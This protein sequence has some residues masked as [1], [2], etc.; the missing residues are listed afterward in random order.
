M[1]T[2]F[3]REESAHSEASPRG[4]L[5]GLRGTARNRFSSIAQEHKQNRRAQLED[6]KVDIFIDPWEVYSIL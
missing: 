1:D 2:I 6:C 4:K 5:C 3:S